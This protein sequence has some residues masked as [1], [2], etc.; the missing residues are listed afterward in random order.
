LIDTTDLFKI[1]NLVFD[2]EAIV[3]DLYSCLER[4]RE[5]ERESNRETEKE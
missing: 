1:R 4:E 3:T 2:E 5:R